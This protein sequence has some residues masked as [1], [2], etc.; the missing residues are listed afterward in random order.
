MLGCQAS[1]T[2][3]SIKG[4]LEVERAD[5]GPADGFADQEQAASGNRYN[6]YCSF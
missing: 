2:P 3:T 4:L 5:D 6:A 1:G